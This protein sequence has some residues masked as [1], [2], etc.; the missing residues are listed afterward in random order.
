MK[1]LM[2]FGLF[3]CTLGHSH[4]GDFFGASI[5]AEFIVSENLYACYVCK[6]SPGDGTVRNTSIAFKSWDVKLPGSKFMM[7]ATAQKFARGAEEAMESGKKVYRLLEDNW[8]L[9][10]RIDSRNQ[11]V[12]DLHYSNPFSVDT[13]YLDKD[14]VTTFIKYCR[15]AEATAKTW[16]YEHLNL[17]QPR[18]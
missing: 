1:I 4:G 14:D 16:P 13:F 12:M 5:T 9:V 15:D 3:I 6:I 8:L 18:F 2:V 10:Y 7:P 17:P 11:P